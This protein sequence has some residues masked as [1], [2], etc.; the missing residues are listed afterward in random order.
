M[1][2]LR[3]KSGEWQAPLFGLMAIAAGLIA[4]LVSIKVGTPL[5]IPALIISI[6]VLAVT[7]YRPDFGLLALF[8]LLY[9]RFSDVSIE[10][11]NLPSSAKP[12]IAFLL[13]IAILR[14]VAYKE[15]PQN[16]QWPA[17][18]VALYGLVGALSLFI[19]VNEG[20]TQE[21]LSDFAKDGIIVLLIAI[22]LKR[23][24]TLRSAV[25]VILAAGIFLGTLSVYQQLT[26]TY[27]NPYWGFAQA[28]LMHIVGEENAFRI[29]GP[30]GSPNAFA[31]IML[32][33][34]ALAF[35]RIMVEEK[36]VLKGIAAY[37]FIIAILT[38][39]FT[40]SRNGFATMVVVIVISLIRRPPKPAVMV[41]LI[42]LAIPLINFLPDSYLDRVSTLTDL[43]PGI[44]DE[45][46]A[47]QEVS[48]RGRIS[49]NLAGWMMFREHPIM[50]VG[51]ANYPEYYQQYSRQIGVDDRTVQR[52]AHNLYLQIAAEQG[53]VGLF[54]F[55]VLVFAA[56]Y[57][58]RQAKII[59]SRQGDDEFADLAA[60][61]MVGFLGYL[62]AGIFIHLAYPRHFWLL[63]G[64]AI[65]LPQIARNRPP[66]INQLEF[67][68][69][70]IK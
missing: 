26:M 27:Q 1:N 31:Q 42:L 32:P 45:N 22:F 21:A 39:V 55:G 65:A 61:L 29:G 43:I 15:I 19:A 7:F 64:L 67:R 13:L 58:M 28:P 69:E 10:Y 20:A 62:I 36:W 6:I 68:Y 70:Q 40:F 38:I 5:I 66:K 50:G 16:W 30:M 48:F 49:E 23:R 34:I 2:I 52:G 54:T 12:F 60:A 41:T 51:W 25:W 35:H 4:G 18:L 3:Q 47:V 8:L 57:R 56:F 9:T 24:E 53:L 63:Y 59:F 46:A 14:W 33:V 44:G 37:A 11:L 17:F